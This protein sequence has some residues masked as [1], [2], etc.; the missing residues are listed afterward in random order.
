MMCFTAGFLQD[1]TCEL[2]VMLFKQLEVARKCK[3]VS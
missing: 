2:L 1:L 3:C